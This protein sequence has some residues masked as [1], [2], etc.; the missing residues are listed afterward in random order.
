MWAREDSV[1]AVRDWRQIL[2]WVIPGF[3]WIYT[4]GFHSAAHDVYQEAWEGKEMMWFFMSVYNTENTLVS[5]T[6]PGMEVLQV[7]TL[8]LPG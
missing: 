4:I 1:L 8:F 5:H 6:L 7:L 3:I 2:Y